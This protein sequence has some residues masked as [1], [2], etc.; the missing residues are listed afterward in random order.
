MELLSDL[1]A[2][3]W[4][5]YNVV[6]DPAETHN[7][8]AE[9]PDKTHEM[10]QRWYTEAGNYGVLPLA[11][12]ELARMKVDRPTV[13]RPRQQF[14]YYPDGAPVAFAAAPKLYNRAHSITAEVVMPDEGA[15]G[16]LITHGSRNAGYALFV[17][18]GYLHYIHNYVGLKKFH[19]T[20]TEAIPTG[21]VKLR[22]EFE[23][24][25]DPDFGEGKGSPGRCQL[26]IND[27]LVGNLE[28]PYS[29]PNMFGPLGLSTGY[30]A[31]DSVSP[32]IYQ[33]P[34]RFTGELKQV[35]IDVSGE[36]IQDDEA[37][38]KRLMVQQ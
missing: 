30:A 37:E 12:A 29:T 31:F 36:V 21:E 18:D 23:P 22:Y 27:K 28:I 10:A 7:L 13:S 16:I 15:E 24:T 25:G 6:E 19:V 20:S 5:L 34:F 4:E 17:K 32:D 26:Y 2:N 35:V 11:S 38:L 33:A 9:M 8:A 3:G 14:V 1:D